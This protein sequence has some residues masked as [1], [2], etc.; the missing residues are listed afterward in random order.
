VAKKFWPRGV[1]PALVTPFDPKFEVDEEALRRLVDWVIERGV[2]AVVPC[3]TTGEFV[4]MRIEERRRVYD[5]VID[6]VNGRVPVIAGTGDASTQVA[7]ELTKYAED[8]G[9]DAA[10]IVT[11]FYMGLTDKEVYE[12][13]E[14]I[15]SSVE[16]PILMYNIPQVTG[17]WI[18][19]WVAEGLG[20]EISNIVGIKDSSGSMPY[21]MTLIEKLYGVISIICGYDE[22]AMAALASGADGLIL[23]SAN[24]IPDVWVE[25]Y[26]AV[27]N[28][29]DLDHARE[30][31][32]KYQTLLRFIACFGGPLAVKRALWMMGLD[33][34]YVRRPLMVGGAHPYEVEDEMRRRLEGYGLIPRMPVEFEL[35]PGRVYRCDYPATSYTHPR[36]RDFT[37]RVGEAFTSPSMADV[38]H[39]DL[40]LGRKDGP[41]G[42]AFEDALKNPR[43]GHEPRV[44]ELD[45]REVKPRTLLIPTV[46]IRTERHAKLVYGPAMAGV[47]RAVVEAVEGGLIPGELVDEL[48]MIAHVFVH[49]TACNPTRIM[50]NNY[51]AV[52]HALKKALEDRPT[53]GEL[54]ERKESARHPF[55]YEP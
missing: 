14:K 29:R 8:A 26:D 52:N 3:G 30:L 2:S 54:M 34:G 18:P 19:W 38:A 44:V 7:V 5:I 36:I 10:L 23:A 20:K 50:L 15:A 6:H 22:I 46:T 9:A 42:K 53:L 40:M 32:R 41:V 4:N 45:G 25:I 16:L 21:M 48:V 55:R 24:V 31:H 35:E 47:A 49:P 27:K 51:K 33:V 13:Y 39:V 37:L 28:K 11:P 12:H 17:V 1:M 43:P